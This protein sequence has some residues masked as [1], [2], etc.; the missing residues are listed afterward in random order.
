MA[1]LR[2]QKR[3]NKYY[4]YE[5]HQYWDKELKKPRQKTKY[6]GMA[7]EDKGPYSK[8]GRRGI[9]DSPALSENEILDCGDSYAVTEISQMTGLRE[10]MQESFIDVDSLLS[11]I[12]FQITEGSAMYN[13]ADWMEGNIAKRLF[14][15]AKVSSQDISRHIKFLGKQEV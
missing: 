1:T 7:D 2:Y 15:K 4:V 9:G 11:L 13:C 12:C 3:G 14:P 8:P 5:V 6:L 10:V